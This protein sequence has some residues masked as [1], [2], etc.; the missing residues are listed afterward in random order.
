MQKKSF[1]RYFANCRFSGEGWDRKCEAAQDGYVF[2]G[3]EKKNSELSAKI[4]EDG[5]FCLTNTEN[6]MVEKVGKAGA[7]E[8][9]ENNISIWLTPA[10]NIHRSP[11]CGRNF[12]YYSEDPHLAGKTGGHSENTIAKQKQETISRWQQD[13]RNT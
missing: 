7:E 8:V 1:I 10:C 5:D 13:I 4:F 11:L 3:D 2:D 12:E 9:K 6:A